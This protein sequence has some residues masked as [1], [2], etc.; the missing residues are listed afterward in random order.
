M[1]DSMVAWGVEYPLQRAQFADES[2]VNSE[3]EK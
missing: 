1:V 2:S 3:L